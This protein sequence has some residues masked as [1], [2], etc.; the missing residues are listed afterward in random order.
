[1]VDELDK[2]LRKCRAFLSL[3]L[4]L[5]LANFAVSF[6]FPE[7]PKTSEEPLESILCEKRV[8]SI[9]HSGNRLLDKFC[10][11]EVS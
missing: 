5:V 6:K 3:A 7:L 1:M 8:V 9:F 11:P 10:L 2:E 4:C